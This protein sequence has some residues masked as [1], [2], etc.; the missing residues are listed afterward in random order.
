MCV[1]VL[2]G[3]AGLRVLLY[4]L[5]ILS[6]MP[7]PRIL[8]Y[9]PILRKIITFQPLLTRSLWKLHIKSLGLL[10]FFGFEGVGLKE[11]RA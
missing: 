2:M 7:K 11:L 5:E 9:R 6:P 4:R 8:A 10:V 3:V 1:R